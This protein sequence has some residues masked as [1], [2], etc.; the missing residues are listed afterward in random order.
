MKNV[1]T[2][3]AE[4]AQGYSPHADVECC[5][6]HDWIPSTIVRWVNGE[7]VCPWHIIDA[8]EYR[9]KARELRVSLGE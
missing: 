8:T 3:I 7:P 4:S 1:F 9:Q 5:R 6:C 2:Y